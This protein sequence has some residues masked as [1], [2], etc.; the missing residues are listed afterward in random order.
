[1]KE[2]LRLGAI[3]LIIT[4]VAG[5]LLGSAYVVTKEPIAKQDELTKAEA[6]KEVLPEASEFKAKDAALE[7]VVKEVYEGTASEKVVGYAVKVAPKGYGGTIELTVGIST[8]GKVTGIKITSLSETP[9][10][11]ANAPKPKF[12]GQFKGK[13][14]GKKLQVVKKA[15][16]SGNEI[17]AIT[18]ATITSKAVTGGVNEAINFYNNKLKGAAN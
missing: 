9:G 5:L 10:L 16:S 11:G 18:G 1:M 4:A 14:I 13:P 3:L 12:S 2:N 7:G 8:E 15:P 17:E 6:M